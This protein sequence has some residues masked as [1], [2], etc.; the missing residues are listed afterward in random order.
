MFGRRQEAL[1]QVGLGPRRRHI[2]RVTV[3][4]PHAAATSAEYSR[5]TSRAAAL[6]ITVAVI[7]IALKAWAWFASSSVAMLAS[8]ADSTLDLAA[9]LFTYFAVRYAAAPP[10]REH[11]FGHGKAEAFAGL[12]QAGLVAVSALLIAF[13]AFGRF[14]VP[15]PITAGREA[16]LVMLA[17]IAL[18]AG[19]VAA[20]THALKRTGSIATRGDRLHYAGDLGAN[21]VVI[22]GIALGA[23]FALPWADAVAALMI[24]A[25]LGW[26]AF[27][28]SRDSAD[29]LLDRELADPERAKIR[30]LAEADPRIH[31]VHDL[32]TRTSGPYVHIQFHADLDPALTLD[33]AHIIVVAAEERIRAAYPAADIII[34]PDPRGKAEPHGHEDFERRATG[35]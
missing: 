31:A 33:Q 6:S 5:L 29:H 27:K 30:E 32:R 7:L 20:Q 12:V 35:G 19:L 9:S 1:K 14:L 17:S 24:A 16:V 26:G 25:W 23:Y 22:I 8:L 13:E 4:E 3:L 21:V 28:I 2:W 15:E 18:T 11:R 10:D 34:H